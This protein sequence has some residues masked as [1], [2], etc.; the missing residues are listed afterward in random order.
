MV[1][2]TSL[3]GLSHMFTQ[4]VFGIS[5][6]NTMAFTSDVD[7]KS[8]FHTYDTTLDFTIEAAHEYLQDQAGYYYEFTKPST[9]AEDR[10]LATY[11]EQ[12]ATDPT[13]TSMSVSVT[14]WS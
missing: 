11:T 7:S 14:T 8:I 9:D 1:W 6:D 10:N 13:Y 12:N 4:F 3:W 2:G 5:I